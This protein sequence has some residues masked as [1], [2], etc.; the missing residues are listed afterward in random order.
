L[1]SEKEAERLAEMA[2]QAD[3]ATADAAKLE[4]E[5]LATLAAEKAV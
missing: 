5:K 1:F 2:A 4:E 3:T